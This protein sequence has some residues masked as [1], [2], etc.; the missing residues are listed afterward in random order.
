MRSSH[1]PLL[2]ISTPKCVAIMTGQL[3]ISRA[4][5]PLTDVNELTG[6]ML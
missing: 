3:V 6:V 4:Y 2:H 1:M 5:M